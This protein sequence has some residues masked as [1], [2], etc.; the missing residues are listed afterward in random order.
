MWKHMTARVVTD[1]NIVR[2]MRIAYCL[3][4]SLL[5]GSFIYSYMHYCFPTATTVTR[6]RLNVT[7]TRT[8]PVL[9]KIVRI[10]LLKLLQSVMFV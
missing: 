4:A 1:H 3:L 10:I 8:L 2:R 7:F 9:F 6:T 5:M